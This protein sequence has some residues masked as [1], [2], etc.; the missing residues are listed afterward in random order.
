MPSA[1]KQTPTADASHSVRDTDDWLLTTRDVASRWQCSTRHVLRLVAAGHLETVRLPHTRS[2]RFRPPSA[3][4]PILRP[5][6]PA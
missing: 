5:H 3:V 2:L 6:R 1:R 4:Q